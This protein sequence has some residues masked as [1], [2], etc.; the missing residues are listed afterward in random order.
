MNVMALVDALLQAAFIDLFVHLYGAASHSPLNTTT[1]SH[2]LRV[3]TAIDATADDH[4][5]HLRLATLRQLHGG[6]SLVQRATAAVPTPGH[7]AVVAHAVSELRRG[8]RWP[9]ERVTADLLSGT[10]SKREVL[11]YIAVASA[12]LDATAPLTSIDSVI[13]AAA[14]NARA[15]TVADVIAR[16]QEFAARPAAVERPTHSSAESA[17]L[18]ES[19]HDVPSK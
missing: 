19:S 18:A 15:L 5:L 10:L 7:D 6:F 8:V 11:V 9:V 1:L 14:A 2:A 3:I 16:F 4:E 12:A 17:S 13:V